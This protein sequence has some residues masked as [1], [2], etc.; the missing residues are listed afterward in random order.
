[1][2][3]EDIQI[4]LHGNLLGLDHRK[5]L[6]CPQGIV[7]GA[8]GTNQTVLTPGFSGTQRGV[9][10]ITTYGAKTGTDAS[11]AIKEAVAAAVADNGGIVYFP[12]GEWLAQDISVISNIR[13]VGAG[14]NSTKVKLVNG[15]TAPLFRFK[16]AAVCEMAGWEHLTLEGLGTTGPDGIDMSLATSWQFSNNEGLRITNFKKGVYGSQ[17]D[18]RPF[19]SGCQLWANDAGYYVI[20]NHPHF[21]LCDIRDNNY[22]ITGL[23]LYDMQI[24]QTAIVRNNYGL[25]PDTGGSITQTSLTNC[26]I[27]GNYI[28]G[29]KVKD[30]VFFNGCLLAAGLNQDVNSVGIEFTGIGSHW[31]GGT[32]RGEGVTGFGDAA[33][34]INTTTDV[35]ICNSYVNMNNFIRTN[36]A[37]TSFRRISIQNNFGTVRGYFAKLFVT[38]SNGVQATVIS[39][40][41]LE[42]PSTGG[43]LTASDGIIDINTASTV[44]GNSINDNIFHCLDAAY[45]AYAIQGDIRSAI[46]TGNLIRQTAGI[47][48]TN[49]DINT[50]YAQNRLPTGSQ[51]V[52]LT[53]STTWDIP[54]LLA[55]ESASTTVTVTS[56]SVGDFAMASH[57][58]SFGGLT[59]QAEVT[60]S[61]TVTVTVVNNTGSTVNVGSGRLRAMVFKRY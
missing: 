52:V 10:D 1:M 25:V 22:G 48:V 27:F 2:A 44:S 51:N 32:I 60:A 14:W 20:N 39:G 4:T 42:I 5:R 26:Y 9:Y 57:Q 16:S 24:D 21:N 54:S 58:L 41:T 13:F 35:S 43:L 55:T 8:P 6:V 56:A 15:A 18:R 33:F 30:R 38:G 46:V 37:L 49:S 3:E 31:N 29:A 59:V 45:A 53:G 7:L 40:N 50:V 34:V 36:P 12:P 47:N 28:L 61:N 23:T 17:N 19:F 11:S